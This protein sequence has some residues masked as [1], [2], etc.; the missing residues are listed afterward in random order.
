MM[1]DTSNMNSSNTTGGVCSSCLKEM[2]IIMTSSSSSRLCSNCLN[3]FVESQSDING[4]FSFFSSPIQPPIQQ[5][6]HHQATTSSL[7]QPHISSL[8]SSSASSTSS[9][10]SSNR[11]PSAFD[12]FSSGNDFKTN[13]FHSFNDLNNVFS[14]L[15]SSN[16]FNHSNNNELDSSAMDFMRYFH[17]FMNGNNGKSLDD[18]DSP[19]SSVQ[20]NDFSPLLSSTLPSNS[21]QSFLQRQHSG[22]S[23]LDSPTSSSP[24]VNRL[25]ANELPSSF[26][27]FANN[28]PYTYCLDCETSLCEKCALAHP[29]MLGFKDHR[30][31][32][33]SSSQVNSTNRSVIGQPIRSQAPLELFSNGW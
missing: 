25:S 16:S 9:V 3:E 8:S 26:C 12:P 23:S 20:S 13:L 18:R 32:L 14:P 33:L 2:P 5:Q 22:F 4:K 1:N 6:Q 7:I 10:T 24:S 19:A 21:S 29:K 11:R 31:Q 30:Q 15:P 28:P 17:N 27:C